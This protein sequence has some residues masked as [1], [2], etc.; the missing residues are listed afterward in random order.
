MDLDTVA[1][2][3]NVVKIPYALATCAPVGREPNGER[4]AS[5]DACKQYACKQCKGGKG[6]YGGQGGVLRRLAP[7]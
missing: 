6:G 7:D 5:S 4:R 3:P 1:E 2:V